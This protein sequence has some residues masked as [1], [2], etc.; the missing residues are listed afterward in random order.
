MA[1]RPKAYDSIIKPQLS[2]ITEWKRSGYTDKQIAGLVGIGYT[3]LIENRKKHPELAQALKKGR[4]DL[5][6]TLEN[7]LYKSANGGFKVKT[8]TKKYSVDEQGTRVGIMEITE[9]YKE[10]EPKVGALVFALK[11]LA[12]DKWQDNTSHTI[13]NKEM[14]DAVKAFLKVGKR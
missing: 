2:K 10:M 6:L 7:S 13:D 5:V 3:T 14:S 1:G 9:T 8:L 12:S 11:N 4:D